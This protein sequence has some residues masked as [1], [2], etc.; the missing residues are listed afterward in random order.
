[1]LTPE[2]ENIKTIKKL[3]LKKIEA[4]TI[5][6]KWLHIVSNGLAQ[7]IYVPIMIAKGKKEGPVLGI[8][9]AVHGNELNGISIIQRLF[10]A[11]DIDNLAG[12]I[13]G[14]PVVN[15][16]ALINNDRLFPDQQ[17]LNRIMPGNAN[18]NLSQ[19]YAHRVLE[20]IVKEFDFLLDLHT[21]SFGRINSYYIRA[22]LSSPTALKLAKLQEP[23]II[24]NAPPTD[25]T[26][27][28][29]AADLGIDAITIEVGNPNKFQKGMIRSGLHGIYNTMAFLDM[30][31]DADLVT[32]TDQHIV[33]NS[34]AW[35]Y[36]DIG[37]VLTVLPDLVDYIKEGDRIAVV[38]NIF[39]ET[40]KEY[41]APYD[42]V[43]I[44]KSTH[45]IAQAGSRII[46]LGKK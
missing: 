40:L 19:V 24:L 45:P 23:Q 39:G 41:Y 29:A 28:G 17:D 7:P 42:G 13:V 38:K 21:A 35:L 22:D 36:T 43:V 37:G 1:M 6:Y 14:V 20:R 26:L 34:S 16:P 46:H 33:C 44:G 8:T 5:T 25:G 3:N 12:V 15:V 4:G 2:F 11:I 10:G 31:E 18:G 32:V 27:R 9:A 30:Y